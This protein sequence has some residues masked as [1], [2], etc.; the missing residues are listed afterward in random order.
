MYQ[1]VCCITTL[2]MKRKWILQDLGQPYMSNLDLSLVFTVRPFGDI[3]PGSK[4]LHQYES[5]I[6]M[7]HFILQ[8]TCV[9]WHSGLAKM[10]Q[11]EL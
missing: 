8:V 1:L 2:H 3:L 7:A 9:S 4:V 10:V 6:S 11:R 5:N